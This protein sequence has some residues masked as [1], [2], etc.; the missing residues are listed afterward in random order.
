M[1]IKARIK[2]GKKKKEK[3]TCYFASVL[4]LKITFSNWK[5]LEGQSHF[6]PSIGCSK[7]VLKNGTF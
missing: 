7:S 6:F 1:R 3:E 5:C 2:E 4:N